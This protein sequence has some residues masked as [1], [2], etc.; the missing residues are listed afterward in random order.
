MTCI[1]NMYRY[2]S[3]ALFSKKK[4]SFLQ[5]TQ[6]NASKLNKKNYYVH[7]VLFNMQLL[8]VS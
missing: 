5:S 2:V 1:I 4:R 3:K 8:F 6:T 7:P